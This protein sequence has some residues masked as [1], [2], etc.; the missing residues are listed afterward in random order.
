MLWRPKRD[1]RAPEVV[2]CRLAVRVPLSLAKGG[3]N[4]QGGKGKIG[5]LIK[6]YFDLTE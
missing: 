1:S 3:D 5:V 4:L 6:E 2:C